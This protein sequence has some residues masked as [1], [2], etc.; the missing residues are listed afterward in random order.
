MKKA[1]EKVISLF[2]CAVL[3]TALF[4]ACSKGTKKIDFIYPFSADVNSYDPQ[5]AS[6]ADEYLIIENTFEGLIRIDDD[7]TVKKGCAESWDVSSNGLT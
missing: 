4:S 7:G 1:A 3:V 2:L 5:V 6:T